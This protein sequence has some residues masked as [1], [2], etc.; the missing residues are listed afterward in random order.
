MACI[1]RHK[2]FSVLLQQHQH[3]AISLLVKMNKIVQKTAYNVAKNVGT[4]TP[5]LTTEQIAIKKT[6][7]YEVLPTPV[8]SESDKKEYR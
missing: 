7:K 6:F 4:N 1:L 8:K 5:N 3:S 2:L